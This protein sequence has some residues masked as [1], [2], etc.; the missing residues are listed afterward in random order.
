[1][2]EDGNWAVIPQ[3]EPCELCGAQKHMS[4]PLRNQPPVRCVIL[5]AQ[6]RELVG[7]VA[8]ANTPANHVAYL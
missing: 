6:L 2:P 3:P 8:I 1:M 7:A 5:W 4:Q